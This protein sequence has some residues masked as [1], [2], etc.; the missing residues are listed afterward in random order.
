M[1]VEI[2]TLSD[3]AEN[4]NGKLVIVGTFD[5]IYAQSFPLVQPVCAISLRIRFANSQS[6]V[7]KIK[8]KLFDPEKNELQ[9]I[10]GEVT[11][12]QSQDGRSYETINLAMK[13]GNLQFKTPGL[14]S[15]ELHIDD[16][17][18]SGLPLNV[19]RVDQNLKVA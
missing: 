10:D 11:V 3:Y 19:V 13:V 12:K 18:Q 15:F 5:S 17:W 9:S 6:G 7:H 14:Y 8:I 2:F 4:F 16:E 1:E